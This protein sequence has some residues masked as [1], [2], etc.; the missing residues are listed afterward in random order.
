M[1]GKHPIVRHRWARNDPGT[2]ASRSRRGRGSMACDWADPGHGT[3]WRG[4]PLGDALRV[5]L[6]QHRF[7]GELATGIARSSGDAETIWISCSCGERVQEIAIPKDL[8]DH[9]EKPR[10]EVSSLDAFYLEHRQ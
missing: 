10:D 4:A 2:L 7:C 8:D 9:A 3:E 6:L 5:F 1:I